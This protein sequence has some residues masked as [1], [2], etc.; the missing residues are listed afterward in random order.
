TPPNSERVFESSVGPVVEQGAATAMP[1]IAAALEPSEQTWTTPV[2]TA[3]EPPV[4]PEAREE[5]SPPPARVAAQAQSV[6]LAEPEPF[7]GERAPVV[8]EPESE[9]EPV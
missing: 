6:D 9:P 5:E 2:E 7:F 8:L 4:M 1:D 3:P